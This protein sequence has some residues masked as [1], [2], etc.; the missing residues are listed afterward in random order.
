MKV[1]R[2]QAP[3]IHLAKEIRFPIA[4]QV[5]L[6]NGIKLLNINEGDVDVCRMDIIFNAGSRYQQKKL[7]ATGSLSLIT[8]GTSKHTSQQ[9]SEHF[10][11]LGSFVNTSTDKDFAR[12]TA[13]S[14]NRFFPQTLQMLEEILKNPEY[15]RK[16]VDIWGER[17]KQQLTVEMEK[18]STLARI[19]F[20]GNVF[21]KNHPYGMFAIPSDYDAISHEYLKS[22]HSSQIGSANTTI[23]LSGKVTPWHTDIIS[24]YLG[25]AA[26]GGT[27]RNT[28]ENIESGKSLLGQH[29]VEK[30]NAIQSAIRVGGK[31]FPRSHPDYPEMTVI[32]TILGGYFG[33]RLMKNIREDKG[34]TYGVGSYVGTFRDSGFFIIATDVGT[35]YTE[36]T[37]EEIRNEMERL[38]KEP[39]SKEEIVHVQRYLSGDILRSFNGPFAIADNI[40]SLLNFNNLDYDF[41]QRV[42]D[43]IRNITPERIMELSNKWLSPEKM[44]ECVAGSKSPFR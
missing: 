12:I 37:L 2:K 16:E 22:F 24:N 18:T 21:G 32:N 13:S 26:W 28:H 39:V 14:L 6:T 38:R 35:D 30:P 27:S 23:V 43:A 33:S 9:I 5:T 8:E 17:N 7:Q 19:A 44:V 29:F 34:Y 10:D 40:I 1:N 42:L 3:P 25:S 36:K 15:P 41:Y 31:L 4:E 11:Y 20:F